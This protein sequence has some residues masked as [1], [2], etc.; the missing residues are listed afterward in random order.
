MI[1]LVMITAKIIISNID[2]DCII[3]SIINNNNNTNNSLGRN[4]F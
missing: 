2:S 4:F 3:N 1:I